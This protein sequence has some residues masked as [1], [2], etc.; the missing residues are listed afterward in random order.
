MAGSYL[1]DTNTVIAVLE[2]DRAVLRRLR[3][4]PAVAVPSIVIGELT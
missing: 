1:L 2:K 4:A 3:Q